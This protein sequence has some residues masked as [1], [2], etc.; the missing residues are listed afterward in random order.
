MKQPNYEMLNFPFFWEEA[1]IKLDDAEC[2]FGTGACYEAMR[3]EVFEDIDG[4]VTRQKN[5]FGS[6]FPRTI[7]FKKWRQ[8][9][10]FMLDFFAGESCCDKAVSDLLL[11]I[12][13]KL[14][15]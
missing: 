9:V 3:D 4:A 12:R 10:M 15:K 13:I 5:L 14:M 8:D 1:L 2:L 7:A 11:P 6:Y